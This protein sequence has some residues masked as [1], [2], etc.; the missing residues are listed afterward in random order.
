MYLIDSSNSLGDILKSKT[1]FHVVAFMCPL[2]RYTS[3]RKRFLAKIVSNF[4]DSY[5][6]RFVMIVTQ[7]SEKHQ[8]ES[9]KKEVGYVSNVDC[10]LKKILSNGYLVCPDADPNQ[11]SE[12]CQQFR[13][14]F[15]DMIYYTAIRS[16][17]PIKTGKGWSSFFF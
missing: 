9:I 13:N 2:K 11:D 6:E 17:T 14:Q 4:D 12:L 3:E 15:V 5:L 16:L 8:S 7:C 1:S 10:N